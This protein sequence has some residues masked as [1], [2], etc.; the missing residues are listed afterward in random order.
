[1][2]LSSTHLRPA[3][4]RF[5]THGFHLRLKNLESFLSRSFTDRA[6]FLYLLIFSEKWIL[7][8]IDELVMRHFISLLYKIKRKEKREREKSSWNFNFFSYTIFFYLI[9]HLSLSLA[10]LSFD[11][12]H[13]LKNSNCE[14]IKIICHDDKARR[15][16]D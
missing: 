2:I 13:Y 14:I 11:F 15:R 16:L 7:L 9:I 10:F 4:A 5:Q 12:C 6:R 8:I 3:N 1:M